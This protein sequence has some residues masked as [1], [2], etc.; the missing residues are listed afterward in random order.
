VS[1][2]ISTGN[3]REATLGELA[4]LILALE[5]SSPVRVA[6]DGRIASGKTTFA[7][8]LGALVAQRNREVIRT[9]IDGFHRP[10]AERYARGRYSPEGYYFDARDHLGAI[11]GLL[12][13]PLR[14]GGGRQYR[15]ASFDLER[16]ATIEQ[17]PLTASPKSVLVVDGWDVAVFLDTSEAVS[18]RRGVRRDAYS[19]CAHTPRP[20]LSAASANEGAEWVE[21]PQ[22]AS[23]AV[24]TSH[25]Q[26]RA[27]TS[28]ISRP[29]FEDPQRLCRLPGES[30]FEG[31]AS[32]GRAA[33]STSMP[34]RRS[35]YST[36]ALIAAHIGGDRPRSEVRQCACGI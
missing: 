12:L 10:R 30:R 24:P 22:T 11:R 21:K 6:I 8:E 13:D 18:E 17:A 26:D 9:S 25:G 36:P 7:N 28:H 32:L 27:K 33:S 23:A 35:V 19:V 2:L 15:T 29:I 4:R 20:E 34:T 1:T 3:D 16:D 14:P 5:R 31:A